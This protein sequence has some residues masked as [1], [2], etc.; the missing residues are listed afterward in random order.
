MDDVRV[1]ASV[2]AMQVL[3][4]VVLQ[5]AGSRVERQVLAQVFDLVWPLRGTARDPACDQGDRSWRSDTGVSSTFA[6]P[7]GVS[8]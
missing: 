1:S 8:P 5:F 7:Q 6:S 2:P 4:L 3:A